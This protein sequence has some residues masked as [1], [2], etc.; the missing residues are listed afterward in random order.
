M[1][2]ISMGGS[3][4]WSCAHYQSG[5][6]ARAP[7]SGRAT[8]PESR[9]V[10]AMSGFLHSSVALERAQREGAGL[11]IKLR[12]CSNPARQCAPTD[13]W[14]PTWHLRVR[15]M[16]TPRAVKPPARREAARASAPESRVAYA[17][18][19]RFRGSVAFAIGRPAARGISSSTDSE[20]WGPTSLP[21]RKRQSQ[22]RNGPIPPV[23]LIVLIFLVV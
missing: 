2:S 18:P 19:L 13:E 3:A 1:I 4:H 21:R 9:V 5:E 23:L 11:L 17:L 20:S 16:P 15:A 6:A 10:Y 8:T 7:R 14:L 22:K 12:P